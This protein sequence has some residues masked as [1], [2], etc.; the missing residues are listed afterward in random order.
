MQQYPYMVCETVLLHNLQKAS[1][2]QVVT[3]LCACIMQIVRFSTNRTDG[4]GFVN[5]TKKLMTTGYNTWT[6]DKQNQ[7][8][9]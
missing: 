8:P 6:I 5:K 1:C 2:N 4:S 7:Q 9:F 3:L